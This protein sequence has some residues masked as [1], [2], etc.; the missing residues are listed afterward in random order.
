[1]DFWIAGRGMGG[2]RGVF[3]FWFWIEFLVTKN[4][5]NYRHAFKWEDKCSDDLRTV[6]EIYREETTEWDP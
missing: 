2:P 5:E 3:I 1:M 4:L 6:E